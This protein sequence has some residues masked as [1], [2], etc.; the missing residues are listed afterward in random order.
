MEA[1]SQALMAASQKLGEAMY[2]KAQA[3]AAA[4]GAGAAG[5]GGAGGAGQ[6]SSA[7]DDE[8]VVDAEFTEVKDKK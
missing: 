8:K 4:T 7:K 2:A 5:E 6:G 3:E 1:K